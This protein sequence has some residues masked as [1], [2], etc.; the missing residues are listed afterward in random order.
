MHFLFRPTPIEEETLTSYL[1]RIAEENI[2]LPHQLWRLLLPLG[3]HYPQASIASSI[4]H[5]P[6]ALL[7][8]SELERMLLTIKLDL[9]KITYIP[10]YNKFGVDKQKVSHSKILNGVIDQM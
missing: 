8:I 1:N 7:N 10:I 2:V 5:Y 4:D 3:A 6:D 9:E